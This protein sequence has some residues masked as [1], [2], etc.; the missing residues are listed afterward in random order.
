MDHGGVS[1]GLIHCDSHTVSQPRNIFADIHIFRAFFDFYLLADNG[2]HADC[3]RILCTRRHHS[4]A[5]N[6]NRHPQPN[7]H[8]NMI[9]HI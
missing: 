3:L 4:A 5:M 6:S 9:I 7:S 8:W 1:F 2:G